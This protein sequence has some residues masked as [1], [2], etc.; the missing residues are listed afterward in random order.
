MY[1]KRLIFSVVLVVALS[2][3]SS[4]NSK[5]RQILKG[6]KALLIIAPHNFRDEEYAN[7]RKELQ[8]AGMKVTVASTTTNT[9]T[10]MLGMK[11][12]ADT[13]VSKVNPLNYDIVAMPGG[14][15]VKVY[16]D[17]QVVLGIFRKAYKA[18]KVIGAICLAPVV[19]GKAGLLKD[20]HATSWSGAKRMIRALG[21]KVVNKHVVVDGRI[22]TGDGP[23][24]AHEFGRTLA[25][26]LAKQIETQK[27]EKK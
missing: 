21:A 5:T 13:L 9:I 1:K 16:Y 14:S 27:K 24:A 25:N 10:G 19:L 6:R 26:V 8:K 4:G 17:N 23:W 20:R 3:A 22:V 15:G 2:C 12:R 11:T 18:G 7:T